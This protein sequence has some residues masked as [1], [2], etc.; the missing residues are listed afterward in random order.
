MNQRKRHHDYMKSL[1]I[2]YRPFRASP[3]IACQGNFLPM[4]STRNMDRVTC[5]NCRIS[6][7]YLQ[8]WV[9][10]WMKAR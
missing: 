10:D 5:K 3:E 1:K 7:W 8:T 4:K 6:K 9:Q 2:H